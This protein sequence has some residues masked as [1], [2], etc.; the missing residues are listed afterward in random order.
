MGVADHRRG[1]RRKRH[2][3]R[4]EIFISGPR[5]VMEAFIAFKET[6]GY[7][8]YWDALQALMQRAGVMRVKKKD[9]DF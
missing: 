4:V 1:P 5:P 2:V 9:D 8:A 3:G 6:E 7:V